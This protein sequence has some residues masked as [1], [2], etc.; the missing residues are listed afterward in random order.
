M[1]EL[2]RGSIFQ[3]FRALMSLSKTHEQSFSLYHEDWIGKFS[4]Y[5]LTQEGL[6]TRNLDD[7]RYYLTEKGKAIWKNPTKWI[8]EGYWGNR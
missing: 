1:N 2:D 5:T 3:H 6:I 7:N 8:K 4:L